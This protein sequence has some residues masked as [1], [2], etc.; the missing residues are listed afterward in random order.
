MLS[1]LLAEHDHGLMVRLA[2]EHLLN[3]C[4]FN[5]LNIVSVILL[6]FLFQIDKHLLDISQEGLQRGFAVFAALFASL[7]QV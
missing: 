7:F 1:A 4:K 3:L 5:R 2:L 6:D